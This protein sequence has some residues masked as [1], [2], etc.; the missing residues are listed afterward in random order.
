MS[1][2]PSTL[3]ID[4]LFN[5]KVKAVA[6]TTTKFSVCF[7]FSENEGNLLTSLTFIV[8]FILFG[9]SGY[10]IYLT[11]HR[12]K[13]K[14]KQACLY[15]LISSPFWIY[16]SWTSQLWGIFAL[17]IYCTYSWLVGFYN[18]YI[19]PYTWYFEWFPLNQEDFGYYSD[20][21]D[22]NHYGFSLKLF[23]VSWHLK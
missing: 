13:D 21:Y 9:L 14:R 16:S 22:G 10:S 5:D 8:Q 2:D 4:T 23:S 6:S 18:N 7:N 20:Y 15:G 3:S 11:Q 12:S 19:E 1:I 17:N